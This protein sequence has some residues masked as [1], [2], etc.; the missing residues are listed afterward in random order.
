MIEHTF[1]PGNFTQCSNLVLRHPML[2]FAA[3]GVL[4]YLM[5]MSREYRPITKVIASFN[6][7]LSV[8]QVQR[9]WLELEHYGFIKRRKMSTGTV[10]M[11]VTTFAVNPKT[12]KF[13]KTVKKRVS[14]STTVGKIDSNIAA[15]NIAAS[16]IAG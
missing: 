5:S 1:M 9:I 6:R 14:K 12:T 11:I 16:N 15:S 4:T 13:E 10:E 7:G 3:V 8:R 2:S